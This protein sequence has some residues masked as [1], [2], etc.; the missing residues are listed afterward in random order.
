MSLLV[1][2]RPF[3]REANRHPTELGGQ[4]RLRRVV[5]V[6]QNPARGPTVLAAAWLARIRDPSAVWAPHRAQ[7]AA[8]ERHAA[9]GVCVQVQHPDVRLI[10]ISWKDRGRDPP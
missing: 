9:D 4:K 6:Y 2:K 5:S 7:T 10:T 8:V 1:E 3:R